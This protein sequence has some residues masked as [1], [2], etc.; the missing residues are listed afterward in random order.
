[1]RRDS[2]EVAGRGRS[3]S[4][5]YPALPRHSGGTA[6]SLRASCR[7]A[8]FQ[9]ARCFGAASQRYCVCFSL[10]TKTL[11]FYTP[12]SPS[13]PAKLDRSSPGRVQR[14]LPSSGAAGPSSQQSRPP[15]GIA[16]CLEQPN[17]YQEWPKPARTVHLQYRRHPKGPS[18]GSRELFWEIP[19]A[20]L[21]VMPKK[22]DGDAK[23]FCHPP[24]HA[25]A[26]LRSGE[27]EDRAEAR[28]NH[29]LLAKPPT[30]GET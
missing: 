28:R 17:S 13:R 26:R 24:A 6:E 4:A 27:M 16:F 2:Y 10:H 9:P 11:L 3:F 15:R 21:P 29:F 14:L 5:A 18:K 30:Q 23:P 1:M 22:G 12:A 19:A 25:R 8:L 20:F 7:C